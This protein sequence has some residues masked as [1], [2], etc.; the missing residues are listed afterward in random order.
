GPVRHHAGV[1]PRTAGSA[2]GS[3]RGSGHP[4][5]GGLQGC[6]RRV[7]A[8][9]TRRITFAGPLQP[10][11]C[12]P[13]DDPDMIGIDRK[14]R[15]RRAEF[16]STVAGDVSEELIAEATER[17]A[18]SWTPY[19]AA[20]RSARPGRRVQVPWLAEFMGKGVEDISGS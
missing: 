14:A 19:P 11:D 6:R 9:M 1:G 3:A 20:R 8:G 15:D 5:A 10:G 13:G 4:G 16:L 12:V 2:H 17:M 7:G 18:A